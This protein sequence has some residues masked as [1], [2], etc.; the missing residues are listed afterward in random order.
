VAVN[1]R[2]SSIRKSERSSEIGV[3]ILIFPPLRKVGCVTNSPRSDACFPP[4]NSRAFG[5]PG[6]MALLISGQLVG[7]RDD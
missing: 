5:L 1:F 3:D 6:Q 4:E 2:G 7:K